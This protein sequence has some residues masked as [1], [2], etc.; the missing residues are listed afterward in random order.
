MAKMACATDRL[1]RAGAGTYTQAAAALINAPQL[2]L[3]ILAGYSWNIGLGRFTQVN[4]ASR[5]LS[6]YLTRSSPPQVLG[7]VSRDAF[8]RECPARFPNLQGRGFRLRAAS[9]D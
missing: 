8:T 6:K 5:S 7:G 9:P 4:A 3:H 1:L 2:A